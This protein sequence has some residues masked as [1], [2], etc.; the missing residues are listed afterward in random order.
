IRLLILRPGSFDDPIHCQLKQ[1]SLSAEHAYDALSYVWGNASD[2]SP[3]SLNGTPHHITKNLEIALRYLRHRESP[4]VLWVDAICINQSD[5]NERN[6]QVQQ[7]ADIYSQ[8]QRV[9]GWLG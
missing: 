2:T 7:M 1:V 6:H 8:A 9:I 5:I 4:K 3:I